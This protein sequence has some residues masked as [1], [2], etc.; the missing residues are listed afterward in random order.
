VR[1]HSV[2]IAHTQRERERERER[3]IE[4]QEL[5]IYFTKIEEMRSENTE[6]QVTFFGEGG[7]NK[8]II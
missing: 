3:E 5:N 4:I 2:D 8:P 6:V 7:G 1:I